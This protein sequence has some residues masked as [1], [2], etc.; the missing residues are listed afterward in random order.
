MEEKM[1]EVR[2][3]RKKQ[4]I[5]LFLYFGAIVIM[6]LGA[7]FSAFSLI[8]KISFQVLSAKVP[9]IVFGVL[10]FYMGLKYFLMV[11]DFKIELM[12]NDTVFSWNN[13]KKKN[14]INQ[15]ENL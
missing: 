4:I 13:F 12:K 15:E 7:F 1:S 2:G 9:G 5:L 3:N 6:F 14:K 8:N 11:S 10:V